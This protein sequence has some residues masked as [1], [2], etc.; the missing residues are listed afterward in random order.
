MPTAAPHWSP[1][2]ACSR[3]VVQLIT[4]DSDAENC[5]T[6]SLLASIGVFR[7]LSH[8]A[9]RRKHGA[10]SARVFTCREAA[11]AAG[12]SGLH[13]VRRSLRS[14]DP[15]R[16]V[17]EPSEQSFGSSLQGQESW[18]SKKQHPLVVFTRFRRSTAHP[19]SAASRCLQAAAWH[20]NASPIRRM[21]CRATRVLP[22]PTTRMLPGTWR[23]SMSCG[24]PKVSGTDGGTCH[25]KARRCRPAGT[26]AHLHAIPPFC[27]GPRHCK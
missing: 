13:T 8:L 26:P 10:H 17:A 4:V 12:R 2:P 1:S 11:G 22:R 19:Q 15:A 24:E 27:S 7:D 14:A 20:P 18:G 16:T 21:L 3:L 25:R 5:A 23:R 9:R 6:E